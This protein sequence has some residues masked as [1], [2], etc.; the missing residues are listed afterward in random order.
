MITDFN[1][2]VLAHMITNYDDVARRAV[3][4]KLYTHNPM[5]TTVGRATRVASKAMETPGKAAIAGAAVGGG[6][7]AMASNEDGLTGRLAGGLAGAA[8]GAAAGAGLQKLHGPMGAYPPL[9][10]MFRETSRFGRGELGLMKSGQI[11]ESL[12]KVTKHVPR[13]DNFFRGFNRTWGMDTTSRMFY[14]AY[15]SNVAKR[16]SDWMQRTAKVFGNFTEE[17][18]MAAS[19][20]LED[21]GSDLSA[22]NAATSIAREA[23]LKSTDRVIECARHAQRMFTEIA[24]EEQKYG[25]LGQ[26]IN[27][28]VTHFYKNTKLKHQLHS[29]MRNS[30]LG[31]S[32]NPF[33]MHRDIATLADA[34]E[35]FGSDEVITD[36][37]K[38]VW[39]RKKTSIE[40]VARQKFYTQIKLEHGLP[41]AIKESSR[42]GMARHLKHWLINNSNNPE[43]ATSI[44]QVWQTEGVNIGRFGFAQGNHRRNRQVIEFL[45]GRARNYRQKFVTD[46]LRLAAQL[47]QT[48]KVR[49]RHLSK[50][51]DIGEMLDNLYDGA[52]MTQQLSKQEYVAAIRKLDGELRKRGIPLLSAFPDITE[53][54]AAKTNTKAVKGVKFKSLTEAL[55]APIEGLR[56]AAQL[57]EEVVVRARVMRQKVGD[58]TDVLRP[59]PKIKRQIDG[60]AQQIGF[61]AEEL[62]ELLENLSGARAWTTCPH[63]KRKCCATTSP[64]GPAPKKSRPGQ[65]LASRARLRLC[66]TRSSVVKPSSGIHSLLG[67]NSARPTSSTSWTTSK[68]SSA[69][70]VKR[71]SSTTKTSPLRGAPSTKRRKQSR[72]SERQARPAASDSGFA[73]RF[74]LS[75]PRTRRAKVPSKD[76]IRPRL[77]STKERKL[78]LNSRVSGRTRF[79][80]PLTRVRD[81]TRIRSRNS[82]DSAV[83]WSAEPTTDSRS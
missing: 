2:R 34:A 54:L 65:S 16:S 51:V 67:R 82:S 22:R 73:T 78:S 17:E 71:P 64:A 63:G 77:T 75:Y 5:R 12:A 49:W 9:E 47:P 70:S 25:L 13:I 39:M 44:D 24:E 30:G 29:V 27:N 79:R 50:E 72:E 40:Y 45:T 4:S 66:G 15:R 55:N 33:S 76:S 3:S 74:H 43:V 35:I 37:A 80:K 57:P 42:V 58:F 52:P 6:A 32:A 11:G 41:A 53:R 8:L 10:D 28:Y 83:K 61:K 23:G 1:E 68:R 14:N 59:N 62:D 26:S 21:A 56:M 31:S 46:D 69:L 18:R 19:R 81:H 38:I 20:L 36:L 60:L 48:I 7:G